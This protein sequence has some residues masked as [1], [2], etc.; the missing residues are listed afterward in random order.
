MAAAAQPTIRMPFVAGAFYPESP[1]ELRAAVEGFVAGARPADPASP[2]PKAII[3][4]HAGYVYS[5]AI[6]GSAYA[7]LAP[8]RATIHRVVIAGPSH[9][10]P[11]RGIAIPSVDAFATPLGN[12]PLDREALARVAALPFVH[13]MD[14]AHAMEHSLEVHLPFLQSVLDE[15]TLVPLVV[16]DATPQEVAAAL[17]ALWGGAETL[18][19][20]SS[21]L[22]HYKDYASAQKLD[23]ETGKAIAALQ[24]DGISEAGACG[25]RPIC[26][27][28]ELARRRGMRATMIDLRNSGD[29]AGP[30]D[31][32]VGYGS[33]VFEM[34]SALSE[35]A[36]AILMNVVRDSIKGGLENAGP[37]D[38]VLSGLSAEL[39]APRASFVTF[40]KDG[41]LR[42][43][44]GSLVARQPLVTDVAGNAFRAAFKDPRFPPMTASDLPSLDAAVSVLSAP[45]ELNFDSE[46]TLVGLLR[47][48]V[49]GVILAEGS[50]RGTFLPDVWDTIPNPE[51]FLRRL[52][53]KAGLPE[54][55]WSQTL[56]AWRYTTETF[57]ESV[58]HAIH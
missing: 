35:D 20:I 52:K 40:T 26:G 45:T 56:K 5:G 48:G 27:L 4:P 47:V 2:A 28:L 12:V 29:T 8:G 17:E 34:E 30:R 16:G 55:Y 51:A 58:N 7:R 22:S 14:E 31:R 50:Q 1:A 57:S 15:F 33:F 43:C 38:V 11:L 44:I 53:G 24:I 13:V 10:V 6:A 32:I 46:D 39:T 41:N 49:D 19:V 9:R 3:A 25:R 23:A 21:D 42:G 36:R 37:P 18:V 54:A